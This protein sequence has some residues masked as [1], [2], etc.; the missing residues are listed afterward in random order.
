MAQIA[1][2]RDL[3]DAETIDAFAEEVA[4]VDGLHM[5]LLLTFGDLNAV[6]PGVWS[7]WKGTLLWELYR[8][9]R[10]LMTGQ[11]PLASDSAV[12][13]RFKTQVVNALEGTLPL[14]EVERH[15]A[16]LPDRYIRST[17]PEA[18]ATHLHLI[19]QLKSNEVTLR[20]LTQRKGA[21]ELTICTNDRH[22]LFADI[23]GA[24]AGSGVE[25]LS[26]ELNTREDG[27]VIDV[28][29]LREASTQEA[30][31]MHRY[32]PIERTLRRAVMRD[33]DVASFVER[34]RSHHAPRKRL[35][36]S[37]PRRLGLPQIT[38]ENDSSTH[39]TMIEVHAVDEPGLAYKVASGLEALKLDIVCAKIATEKNDALDVFY[40]TDSDG[41]KLME[42][43]IDE[44]RVA[45]HDRLSEDSFAAAKPAPAVKGRK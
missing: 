42:S 40:V 10:A 18:A 26:A 19:E 39:F 21:T 4:T 8:R 34:W 24:F 13:A 31:A 37:L 27:I 6:G 35:R 29:I 22:G 44:V 38:V 32:A 25:I 14:S 20:W 11:N 45:L 28:F 43:Q 33:L 2:R 30:I 41:S 12:A 1:Q 17:R 23:S 7:D 5:L 9:S 36:T 3:N 15:L 16:L